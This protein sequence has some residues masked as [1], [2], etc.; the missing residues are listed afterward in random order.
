MENNQTD[1]MKNRPVAAQANQFK[2]VYGSQKSSTRTTI[3]AVLGVIVFILM[4][5]AIFTGNNLMMLIFIS[6]FAIFLI[7]FLVA[8]HA[9]RQN[10]PVEP[11]EHPEALFKDHDI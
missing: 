7:S 2:D 11:Q 9:D 4:M 5:I 1:F 3:S 8:K 6:L 10:T